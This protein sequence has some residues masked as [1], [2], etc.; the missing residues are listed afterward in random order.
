MNQ[1]F[2]LV[3]LN[4]KYIHSN[5]G[6][7]SLKSYSQKC[8]IENVKV[9]IAEYTI[10]MQ[11]DDILLD[12]YRKKPS[13]VG[14][15]CYIWNIRQIKELVWEFH[16][17]CPDIPIWL[18]GPE[19]SY[20]ALAVI[21]ELPF[22]AGIMVGEGEVTFTKLC[23]VY[24][25][26]LLENEYKEEL[27]KI[28]G[29]VTKD[30]VLKER[31]L[32]DLSTIPF[33]Y[34]NL[35]LFEHR[36]IYY[37]SSRGCPYRCSYCLS[38][39]DKS[40]RL[41]A[42]ELVKKELKFF[43]EHYV[44]QVKFV[45]RT[46]NCNKEH[47]LSIWRFIKEHD[48]GIT[49][50]HFEISAD[51]LS[52]EELLLLQSMRPGLVQLEIG[53]QSTNPITIQEIKRTM[54]LVKL[55]ENVKQ[56]QRNENIHLHLDLIV[57]LPFE[58]YEVFKASF[59]D[60]YNMKPEQLQ[61]GFLKV[62]KGSYMHEMAKEYGISYRQMPPYEVLF[63]KWISYEE[64][65]V[66]KG[67]EEM[68]ELFFNSGQFINTLRI[69]EEAFPTPFDMYFELKEF[70]YESGYDK[71]SPKRSAKYEFLLEFCKKIDFTKYELYRE[72]LTFDLYLRE[73]MKT[74]PS[75]AKEYDDMFELGKVFYEEEEQNRIFLPEYKEYNRKQ[76]SK[77]T[78]FE[79]FHYPVW[80]KNTKE[81]KEL[82]E[83]P[84]AVLFEYKNRNPL[85]FEAKIMPIVK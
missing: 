35:D 21:K 45:D 42:I 4:A 74:R 83:K 3:A 19:V 65:S 56:L 36:I 31:G 20:D 13:Y 24:E 39:I 46:F 17:I 54:N 15:S 14:F 12:I 53:V 2:L 22:L 73:N 79:L 62:L 1:I 16:K 33:F 26:N 51:I 80:S 72:L 29:I 61:V 84:I 58:T 8:G 49:N 85:T 10:N 75:F 27:S 32:T 66:L 70:Y 43:L 59:N 34:E 40:V 18:G 50:F 63:T 81:V 7:Y 25:K 64:V 28:E 68:V 67:V 48:N 82:L 71:S 5:P 76:L 52:K 78:H 23:E 77:M 38:S 9:E 37:E 60:V 57:G 41:R 11:L 69:L 30:G 6:I 47:A 44:P 55:K